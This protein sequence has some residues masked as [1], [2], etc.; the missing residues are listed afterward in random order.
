MKEFKQL[1]AEI[2]IKNPQNIQRQT[3]PVENTTQAFSQSQEQF[4]E[5]YSAIDFVTRSSNPVQSPP[6]LS[7]I[8][9]ILEEVQRGQKDAW[10]YFE[11]LETQSKHFLS[12]N[13]KT[14]SSNFGCLFH[15]TSICYQQQ[16]SATSQ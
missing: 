13:F 3:L 10:E 16:S 4:S 15:L 8:K 9:L 12:P 7:E 1:L 2:E 5:T 6:Q 11:R 14:K